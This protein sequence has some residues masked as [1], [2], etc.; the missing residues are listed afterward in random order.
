MRKFYTF[1]ILIFLLTN[2]SNAEWIHKYYSSMGSSVAVKNNHIYVARING[3]SEYNLYND[4]VKQHTMMNSVLP[5]WRVNS[6]LKL[7]ENQILISTRKGLA[8]MENGEIS[9]DCDIC[10][11]YPE[12]D[13]RELLIDTNGVVW[14][15]S[16][17][18]IHY[19]ENDN[20]NTINLEDSIKYIFEIHNL[21]LRFH[22][23]WA[24]Y[25]IRGY[26]HK[27]TTDDYYGGSITV[28]DFR[29][30]IVTKDSIDKILDDEPFMSNP[31]T[32][33]PTNAYDYVLWPKYDSLYVYNDYFWEGTVK[34]D[35]SEYKPSGY[36]E[37]LNDNR[38]K[39]WYFVA[40]KNNNDPKKIASFEIATSEKQMYFPNDTANFISLNVTKEGYVITETLENYYLKNNF[41]TSWTKIN[42]NTLVPNN[43][44]IYSYHPFVIKDTVFLFVRY[45][46]NSYYNYVILNLKTGKYYNSAQND[47]PYFGLTNLEVDKFGKRIIN[48]IMRSPSILYGENYIFEADSGWVDLLW[49]LGTKNP[50][51]KLAEDGNIYF[52]QWN[53]WDGVEYKK[54]YLTTMQGDD[55]LFKDLGSFTEKF[56][57]VVTDFECINNKIYAL[58]YYPTYYADTIAPNISIHDLVTGETTNY[59]YTNSEFDKCFWASDGNFDEEKVEFPRHITA[60]TSGNIWILTSKNLQKINDGKISRYN[61]PLKDDFR[62]YNKMEYDAY[63]NE[64]LLHSTSYFNTSDKLYIFSI[65]KLNYD[66]IL[67]A[68]AGFHSKPLMYKKLVDNYLWASDTEGYLYRYQGNGKFKSLNLNSNGYENCRFPVY[69]FCIDPH[70]TLHLATEIGQLSSSDFLT[71]VKDYYSTNSEEIHLYPNPTSDFITVDLGPYSLKGTIDDYSIRIFN[72][73]GIEVLRIEMEYSKYTQWNPALQ[74][75]NVSTLQ[76]GVYFATFIME[77]GEQFTKQFVVIR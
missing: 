60:D 25:Q 69:D 28:N 74:I 13:A 23:V 40:T 53:K 71:G 67:I 61:F 11:K 38:G 5:Y 8:I 29:F 14:T 41:D 17:H 26:S 64:I 39:L 7:N 33:Q 50:I 3:L 48:G 62:S 55:I 22:T 34:F 75:I 36:S 76:Q 49:K 51:I 30:A 35:F 12:E 16:A 42:K 58:G 68:D 77:D 63:T 59:D 6:L 37:I 47:L 19:W 32:I 18:K 21:M 54:S 44:F 15:H 31:G 57:S 9:M 2:I 56:G 4:E 10:E 1:S 52:N 45:N 70:N 20:W 65:D 46:N 66:S 43:G 27:F 73:L 72:V 24:I